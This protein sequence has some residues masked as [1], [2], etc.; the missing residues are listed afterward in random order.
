MKLGINLSFCTKRWVTP[1]LWAPV[2]RERLGLDLVQLSFD[3]VDPCWPD[4]LLDAQAERLRAVAAAHGIVVHSAFVGLAHY[5]HAQLLHPVADVRE[6]AMTWLLRA[7][8][9]AARAGIDAVGGPLGAVVAGAAGVGEADYHDLLARLHRL[10]E[11][12]RA[13][14]L[15]TLYIEPT[16]LPREWPSTIE[17]AERLAADLAGTTLPWRYCL[18]WGHGTYAPLYGA[19]AAMDPWLRRLAPWTGMIHLQQTDGQGDRHWDFTVPG[20]VDPASAAAAQRAAG[21]EHCPAFLEVFYPFEAADEFVLEAV[22]GSVA[23]LTKEGWGA[24]PGP[25]QGESPLDPITGAPVMGSKGD[26]PWRGPGAA[27]L[28]GSGAAPQ[29]SYDTP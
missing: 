28:A 8:R 12:G 4:A 15:R 11:A 20:I 13:E 26:S 6:A 3:L 22:A 23:R 2:V 18:D 21:L 7:Y 29:P 1:E 9:F 19:G 25:R 14:G 17:Q 16:P 5:S 10:A 24:A 27:P